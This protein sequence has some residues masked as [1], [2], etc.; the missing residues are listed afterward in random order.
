MT[1]G[2]N[3][4]RPLAVGLF[5]LVL[6]AA[7]VAPVSAWA[8]DP[9]LLSFEVEVE[10]DEIDF[11]A[12]IQVSIFEEWF[13]V[14]EETVASLPKEEQGPLGAQL[15]KF[16]AE[17][18]PVRADGVVLQPVFKRVRYKEK[19]QEN[20][21]L[22]YARVHFEY[23]TKRVPDRVSFQW[24]YY[25]DLFAIAEVQVPMQVERNKEYE[26]YKFSE[27]EPEAI[28][29]APRAPAIRAEPPPPPP[30]P[31][32]PIPVLSVAFMAIGMLAVPWLWRL[33]SPRVFVVA[34]GV[35]AG[36]T[37]AAST[38]AHYEVEADWMLPAL[39]NDD[40]ALYDFRSLHENVYRAF[41]YSTESEIYD[42]LARSVTA[43][44]LDSV[45]AEVY[46][47][48]ILREEGGAVAKV[49]S[50]RILEAN[51]EGRDERA[52]RYQVR[53]RWRV[54]GLVEHWGHPHLRT[55]LYY[56]VY[57]VQ[58]LDEGWRIADVEILSQERL[59]TTQ[60]N[61]AAPA[62]NG[63]S[64]VDGADPSKESNEESNDAKERP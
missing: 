62:S 19:M 48:L 43:E 49:Q 23:P 9:P 56:A 6:L 40:Q 10:D 38:V 59:D 57:T 37:V 22:S 16:F 35:L 51:V 27:R 15:V 4:V 63:A 2:S 5:W 58:R 53:C 61:S 20:D 34:L 44:L 31:I 24:S 29:H 46:E 39:P 33:G 8:H 60:G 41:D 11:F 26:T 28:W 3:G 30:I 12:M 47:S 45:Y 55:N 50:V 1:I 25:Q 52:V 42:A 17:K 18:G 32:I 21:G 64:A 54:Q 13:G 36:S 7:F 14:S